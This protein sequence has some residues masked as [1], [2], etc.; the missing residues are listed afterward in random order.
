MDHTRGKG[1]VGPKGPGSLAHTS[2]KCLHVLNGA[3]SKPRNDQPL[4]TYVGCGQARLEF[5][6]GNDGYLRH[7]KYNQC[8]RPQGARTAEGTFVSVL[9]LAFR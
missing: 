1:A 6:L 9:T 5:V 7:T 4:V 3:H 8:V 2:G